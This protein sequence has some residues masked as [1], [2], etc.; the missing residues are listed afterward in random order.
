M[1]VRAHNP[2]PNP[3]GMLRNFK[4]SGLTK[5]QKLAL[6]IGGAVAAAGIVAT[7]VALWPDDKP[8]RRA[9]EVGPQCSTYVIDE[10]MLRGQLQRIVRVIAATGPVD[11]FLIAQ[12][13]IRSVAPQCPTYP[14]N[15]QNP[16][17]VRLF[18]EVF[19]LVLDVMVSENLLAVTDQPTW[20]AMMTTWAAGQGVTDL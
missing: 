1:L 13:Y 12:R 9:I 4:L 16:G 6:G 11:P 7:V 3:K 20:Y 18:A 5:N 2:I 14:S 15:T 10:T 17:Q 19:T 8:L